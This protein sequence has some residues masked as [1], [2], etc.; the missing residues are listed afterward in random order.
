M[1]PTA[2]SLTTHVQ[3]ALKRIASTTEKSPSCISCVLWPLAHPLL[4]HAAIGWA[5][6]AGH[7]YHRGGSK[8]ADED[9]SS[10]EGSSSTSS[11]S[12]ADEGK[13]I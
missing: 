7:A 4:G 10:G 13:Q 9:Q 5:G 3:E 2:A 6:T 8:S 1:I 11:S 12:K